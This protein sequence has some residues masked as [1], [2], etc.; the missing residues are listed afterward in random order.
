MAP[1]E[2][3]YDTDIGWQHCSIIGQDKRRVKCNWCGKEMSGDVSRLKEHLAGRQ[4]NVAACTQVSLEVRKQMLA[5]LIGKKK[6]KQS[7]QQRESMIREELMHNPVQ[8]DNDSSEQSEEDEEE[9]QMRRA[10]KESRNMHREEEEMRRSTGSN[11]QRSRSVNIRGEREYGG[12][13][14]THRTPGVTAESENIGPMDTY[15]QKKRDRTQTSI[16]TA[17]KGIKNAKKHI[18]RAISKF[19]FYNHIP[20]NVADSPYYHTMVD[21]IQSVRPGVP[22]PSSND[23][24]TKYLDSEVD[25]FHTYIETF[26]RYWDEFGCTLM[27]DGWSTQNRRNIINFLV[28]SGMGTI[29]LKSVDA[30]AHFKSADYI[31]Q[32]M[33]EVVQEIGEKRVVQVVT[34]NEANYKAAGNLLMIKRPHLYWTPYAA[35]CI[36]LMLEDIAKEPEIDMVI[37]EGQRL[38]NFIYNHGWVLHLLRQMT[39][40]REIIR[41]DVT[42]FATHF[43]A[44]ESIMR[45]KDD[46]IRMFTSQEWSMKIKNMKPK[47][48]SLGETLKNMALANTFWDNI[49]IATAV[50]EPFVKVLRLVDSDDKSEMGFLY[51]AMN[52]AKE[53]IKKMWAKVIRSGGR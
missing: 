51:E 43:L 40:G 16:K 50:F 7:A 39:G 46:I 6:D 11:F 14:S 9:R 21:A 29:F 32:L 37:C 23:I 18:G 17:L 49:T 31:C 13:S 3:S 2:K 35:H 44:L 41:P 8:I 20:F 53:S 19:F 1:K 22:P 34:D 10:M 12:S 52:I 15:L 30:T 47:D 33:D 48:K 26:K 4:G 36:D 28:Y 45:Y 24:A 5:H 27:C 25:E 42:R 38:T